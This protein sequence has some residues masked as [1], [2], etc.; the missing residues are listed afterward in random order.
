MLV[1]KP[2]SDASLRV[3]ANRALQNEKTMGN[4]SISDAAMKRMLALCSGDARALLNTIE[5]TVGVA[6]RDQVV[7]VDSQ[8]LDEAIRQTPQ[9]LFGVESHYDCISAIHKSIRASD[10]DA[11]LIYFAR[12]LNGGEPLY[13]ARRLVRAAAEDVGMADPNAMIQAMNALLAVEKVGS[14]GE[15]RFSVLFVA[16][17]VLTNETLV[18]V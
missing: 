9:A 4:V 18:R 13:I 11:A 10:V 14:P 3:I 8:L 17:A 6:Q 15:Q 5:A 12:M 7:V 2:L 1:L 16:H